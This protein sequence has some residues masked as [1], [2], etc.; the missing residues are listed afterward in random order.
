MFQVPFCLVAYMRRIFDVAPNVL[1][2]KLHAILDY[3][4]YRFLEN[5]LEGS[6]N[7]NFVWYE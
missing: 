1:Q 4:G 3:N 7:T 2:A 5:W 6:V